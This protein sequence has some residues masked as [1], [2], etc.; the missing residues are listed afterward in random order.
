MPSPSPRTI[1]LAL[2]SA[3]L[4]FASCGGSGPPPTMSG[5]A[6]MLSQTAVAQKC[7]E[8]AHGHDRPFVVEWD[9]TDLASFEA[10]A[11]R[12]TM[13][14]DYEG[15]TLDVIYGCNDPNVAG[16][17]GTYGQ[18]TSTSGTVQGFDVKNEGELYA[19]LPL[20]AASLSA[21]VAAGEELHL[22]YFVSGVATST[23]DAVYRNEIQ[24]YPGCAKVTHFVWAYNIGAFT[25]ESKENNSGELKASVGG[26][27]TGGDRSHEQ[28]DVAKGGDIASCTT[29]DQRACR[30]PIRLAL[31]AISDGDNPNDRAAA[32]P[33]AA[34]GAGLPPVTGAQPPFDYHSTPAGQAA[35]LIEEGRKKKSVGDG[36]ACLSLFR[37]ALSIDARQGEHLGYEMAECTMLS[38]DCD[39]GTKEIRQVLASRDTNRNRLDADLDREARDTANRECPASTAKNTTDLVLR[40]S[41]EMGK[42]VTA[43]DGD[44]CRAKF[45]VIDAKLEDADKEAKAQRQNHEPGTAIWPWN[46][47]TMALASGAQCIAKA[48]TCDEGLKYYKR[49]Y[50]KMLRN[51]KS[52][53]KIAEESWRSMIKL[54]SLKCK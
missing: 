19:K 49:Y 11:G 35:A 52:T 43:S 53:D 42:A 7:G 18:P 16:H 28:S 27:G 44:A 4:A 22:K 31:R 29:Q 46:A 13:F 30:V 10:K 40:A 26:A 38:G 2:V 37:K 5:R 54:G 51:M 24:K 41:R 47:G 23:R 8:A 39:E 9:A 33:S 15:C 3:T 25:L 1:S 48:T 45:E 20:G 14:V 50:A 32:P 17:L 36:A 12:D 21:R 34:G 6:G